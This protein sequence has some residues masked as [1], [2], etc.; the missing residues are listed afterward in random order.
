MGSVWIVDRTHG[1]LGNRCILLSSA[2]AWCLE[3][4][5]DLYYP[6]FTRYADLF[7]RLAHQ[8]IPSPTDPSPTRASA[9]TRARF[10]HAFTL[11]FRGGSRL[12][13][14]R[15]RY[16]PRLGG[17]SGDLPPTDPLVEDGR[18]RY[19][20]FSWRFTNPLGL[21]KYH[22]QI[23]AMLTPQPE[24]VA[25]TED[26]IAALPQSRMRIGVHVRH[27]DYRGFAN[28]AFY[29]PVES[30][31]RTMHAAA[32]RFADRRPVFVVCSDERRS[33]SEFP[34]L[35]VVISRGNLIEDM[36][37]LSRMHLVIG[38]VST[39]NAF[40]AYLGGIPAWH[41]GERAAAHGFEWNY[42]GLPVVYSLEDAAK[43]V[44]EGA[45]TS[46]LIAIQSA[47]TRV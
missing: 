5:H 14:I 38:P 41:T 47:P 42:R 35:D 30:Y 40:A 7:P 46:A 22:A 11:A 28:G 32:Q 39:F 25:G 21:A 19:V 23:R 6:S 15:G 34:G 31:A 16:R 8:W 10:Q 9:A 12:G 27:R 33:E 43:A 3:C 29:Q 20:L 45:G 17:K 1:Q 44:A 4:G 26:F 37:R 2:Y 24:V 18:K 36:A 13:L